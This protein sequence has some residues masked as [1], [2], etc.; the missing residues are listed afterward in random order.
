[1]LVACAVGLGAAT[2]PAAGSAP[3]KA[4][5]V[6]SSGGR[7][8]TLRADGSDRAA[9]TSHSHRH[10]FM[11]DEQPAWSPDGSRIAFDREGSG[12][13]VYVMRADG[14]HQ[15]P[16]VGTQ[17]SREDY[18][19]TWSP[20]GANLAFIRQIDRP[21]AWVFEIVV[22][23]RDGS[24]PT[25][26]HRVRLTDQSGAAVARIPGEITF[27]PDASALLLTEYR[28][29]DRP[30][31]QTLVRRSLYS[32][33]A[34]GGD[35]T[36]VDRH[37]Y[38][39]SFSPSGNR[40]TYVSEADKNGVDCYEECS[41]NGEIYV[42]HAD[43]SNPHRMTHTKLDEESPDWSADGRYI[44]FSAAHRHEGAK[45][46][47]SIPVHGD[48]SPVELTNMK[49]GAYEADW[50]PDPARSSDPG[51]CGV[52][53]RRTPRAPNRRSASRSR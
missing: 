16:F 4:L 9:L 41:I 2:G 23:K 49:R 38:Q 10:H 22:A 14:S 47:E 32:I 24:S 46:L 40:M 31:G 1:M 44:V 30:S 36:L 7:I 37:A 25:V 8:F 50:Q 15:H 27:S 26:V 20:D 12:L 6:F 19:P 28:F 34:T 29:V 33:P 52:S 48:C 51:V 35:E 5:I 13:H 43:G 18:A 21:H 17:N 39:P 45:Q 11:Y 42:A 3:G 53:A